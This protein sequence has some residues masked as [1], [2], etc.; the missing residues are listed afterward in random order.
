VRGAAGVA[1]LC[2]FDKLALGSSL[3][4]RSAPAQV[5]VAASPFAPF[6]VDVPILPV[7]EPVEVTG[8][9]E[10]YELTMREGIADILPGFETPII[11]YDGRFPG[12]T[13]RVREGR[14]AEV[15]FANELSEVASVHLHGGLV[16]EDSDGG[17]PAYHVPPGG[18]RIHYYPND[19]AP[20]TLWYHDHVHGLTGAHLNAGL[21]AFYIIE[22]EEE[23]ELLPQGEHDVALMIQD[24][25][26]ND[27]GA[28]GYAR[29]LGAGFLGDTILVNGAVA[30]RMRVTRSLYRLRLL[31]A[32]NARTYHLTLGDGRPMDQ[33]AGDSGLLP[34]PVRR[35]MIPLAPAERAE[36]LVNFCKCAPGSEIVLANAGGE[37]STTAVMRF[38]VD[39]AGGLE[40]TRVPPKLQALEKL[41]PPVGNR[42]LTLE[43]A[44][45]PELEWQ[46]NG[47]GFDPDRVDEDP[48]LGTTE[49]WTF[50]NVSEHEHPMHLHGCHFRV[51]SVNGEEPHEGD[52]GW[53]D[54]VN[55]APGAT[56]E[57]MPYFEKFAGRY[58][59]HC[60]T[61]EHGDQSMMGVMEIGT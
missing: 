38:D 36:V 7:L 40:W 9:V 39:G 55:V 3:T 48:R 24:R 60:H 16:E 28:F 57:V 37:A 52:R 4:G 17:L 21:T 47:R 49:V 43:L 41:A 34:H 19:Q 50:V 44:T 31:N 14:R 32:S 27:D 6:Q 11:G 12:P 45:S 5:A 54:T 46:I 51:L 33:I 58:L 1:A 59:F 2:S 26:F 56:V 25:S 8:D 53:K 10:R 22:P 18:E 20:A 61:A 29:N 15:R 30:P 13:I 35:R 42:T 23:H